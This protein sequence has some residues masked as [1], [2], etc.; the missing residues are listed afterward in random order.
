MNKTFKSA[1]MAF[2]LCGGSFAALTAATPVL[3]VEAPEGVDTEIS[4]E[5][6]ELY[7]DAAEAFQE[8][9]DFPAAHGFLA[10]AR[11][12]PELTLWEIYTIEILDFQLFLQEQNLEQAAARFNAAYDTGVLPQED[13]ERFLRIATLVNQADRARAIM[14]GTEAVNYPGW[15]DTS[16]QV[17]ANA[18]YF[19]GDLPGAE[20]FAQSVVAR[21]EAAGMK[22][23]IEILTVLHAAQQEQGKEAEAQQTAG[24]IAIV[25][26]TP[27]NWARVVDYG[28]MAPGLSDRQLLN[29]YRLRRE[30]NAMEGGDYA[31]M[32]NLAYDMGLAAEA[33]SAL[34]E[35]I[36]A[37]KLNAAEL[38]T[39]LT[40]ATA[41]SNEAE[42]GLTEFATVAAGAANGDAQIQ[43]GETLFALGRAAEAEAAIR[44]GI[45]KGGLQDAADVQVL[46]GI[47]LLEQGKKAEAQAAFQQASQSPAMVPVSSAWTLYASM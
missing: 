29:L 16:D 7:S 6:A 36:A 24:Q 3:A 33:K 28:F 22:P 10:E 11:A 44:A 27:Q 14:Y 19:S 45:A 25:D 34:E 40:D 42:A 47:V 37:G 9:M 2:L 32:A 20:A 31:A 13:K 39:A 15:D 41:S 43:Y 5:V 12:L 23:T 18:Y 17:L 38:G 8:D 4:D 21:K 30:T 35:G 1:A 26:P 46:L